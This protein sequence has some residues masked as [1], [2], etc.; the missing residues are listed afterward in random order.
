[1]KNIIT[2]LALIAIVGIGTAQE[3]KKNKYV[4]TG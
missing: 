4:L 3:V 2:L 1:M